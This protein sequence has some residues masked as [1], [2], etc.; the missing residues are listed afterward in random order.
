[1]V[2]YETQHSW[3]SWDKSHPLRRAEFGHSEKVVTCLRRKIYYPVRK[4]ESLSKMPENVTP[5]STHLAGSSKGSCNTG[6][7]YSH[8]TKIDDDD[9]DDDV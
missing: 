8:V 9:D 2:F 4:T 3:D 6:R 5:S 1:M 7:T